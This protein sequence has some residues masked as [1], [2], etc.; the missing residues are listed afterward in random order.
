MHVAFGARREAI[1][2]ELCNIP[3][4]SVE[5]SEGAFYI[6]VDISATDMDGKTFAEVCD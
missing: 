4:L 6:F 2:E 5:K 3:Q 1:F